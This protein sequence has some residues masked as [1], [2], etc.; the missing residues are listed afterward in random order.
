MAAPAL[1]TLLLLLP[2]LP[3]ATD[4]VVPITAFE[5]ALTAE[6]DDGWS[7]IQVDGRAGGRPWARARATFDLPED[8]EAGDWLLCIGRAGLVV[9][10]QI[11]GHPLETLPDAC[12]ADPRLA[13]GP[14][15]L[16]SSARLRTG[17]NRVELVFG[18]VHAGRGL[19]RGPACLLSRLP[20]ARLRSSA[21]AGDL[22]VPVANFAGFA[23]AADDGHVLDR[24]AF[25]FAADASEPRL[26][27]QLDCA[28]VD[29][30]RGVEI[31]MRELKS[32][33]LGGA[34]PGCSVNLEDDRLPNFH[35]I[36]RVEAPVLTAPLRLSDA[37]IVAFEVRQT[38]RGQAF[39]FVWRLRF[40]PAAGGPLRVS[41]GKGWVMVR[42]DLVGLF[43]EEGRVLGPESAPCGL[44]VV[45]VNRAKEGHGQALA[46]VGRWCGIVGFD[47]GGSDP[48]Q[49][50][51]MEDLVDNLFGFAEAGG[52]ALVALG[53]S[54]VVEPVQ[55]NVAIGQPSRASAVAALL[56]MRR[57]RN[58]FIYAPV[59]GAQSAEAFWA[60]AFSLL[61]FPVHERNAVEW[62]LSTQR[63]DGAVAG[64]LP[65][66]ATD[67]E[68]AGASAY[69][70]LRACRWFR[71]SYD[72]D[73]FL[74]MAPQLVRA[75]ARADAVDLLAGA[76]PPAGGERL[77]SIHLALARAAAHREF[78]GVLEQL[79]A[80]P[81][82]AATSA[83]AAV[84]QLDA[85]LRP[86]EQGGRGTEDGFTDLP[87]E[88]PRDAAFALAYGL[89][90][91]PRAAALAAALTRVEPASV[92]L[93]WRDALVLRGSLQAGRGSPL[94][95]RWARFEREVR[96]PA[97]PDSSACAAYYGALCFGVLGIRRED[98]GTV[99]IRPRLVDRQFLR[100]AVPL[101]EGTL[102][103]QLLS[104]TAQLD[105]Q[106][107]VQNDSGLD[108]MV[109]VG[110]PG[111]FGKGRRVKVG[112][113]V[114]T[115][116]EKVLMRGESWREVV[117]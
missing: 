69:A 29:R 31:P 64:D 49:A 59:S 89:L 56:G 34:F 27:G 78:A 28:V 40:F 22:T 36:V 6:G 111:A 58:R 32:R 77:S 76:P 15:F 114:H 16:L 37:K 80:L 79:G 66:E 108:L 63:E 83:Q 9:D 51:S 81:D 57:R 3:P 12:A 18:G 93:G 11:N 61:H 98:L 52:E 45:L 43:A 35:A 103:V 90:D 25:K 117:R 94:A 62:L 4:V 19:E 10:A 99:E 109:V 88:D 84:A 68:L 91:E 42:N 85:L 87:G 104:P 7:T 23:T 115:L 110:V 101:P 112:E 55:G 44:E 21:A 96:T 48:S 106:L 2:Q 17:A 38:S 46:G 8:F 70:V 92:V 74:R 41:R 71:W 24:I 97:L 86:P 107:I 20:A 72:G 95:K 102:R 14:R 105:R 73:R 75:L 100:T 67:A 39:E 53:G 113:S 33:R 1:T 5:A 26:A 54:L 60:D 47:P 116:H 50:G 65:E 82:E 13:A 30:A